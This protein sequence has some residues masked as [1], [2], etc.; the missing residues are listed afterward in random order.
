MQA[1]AAFAASPQGAAYA[2]V[3]DRWGTD[4][5]ASLTDDVMAY[6]FRYALATATAPEP[7]DDS[8]LDDDLAAIRDAERELS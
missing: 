1:L 8:R 7:A 3:C 6:N 5:A 4:P 2:S